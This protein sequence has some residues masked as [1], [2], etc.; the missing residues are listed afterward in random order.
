[1]TMKMIELDDIL[2]A[3]ENDNVEI[4]LDEETIKKAKAPI[5]RMIDGNLDFENE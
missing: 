4:K 2:N 1:M 5:I 3:L